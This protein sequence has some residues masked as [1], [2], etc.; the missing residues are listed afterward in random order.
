MVS[1]TL[2]FGKLDQ[3]QIQWRMMKQQDTHEDEPQ[4]CGLVK[5]EKLCAPVH[6]I[7]H[8]ERSEGSVSRP[9]ASRLSE[10]L[11]LRRASHGMTML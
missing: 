11:R 10:I 3:L 1:Q 7:S 2:D 5:L 4:H 8:P 6:Q 9:T